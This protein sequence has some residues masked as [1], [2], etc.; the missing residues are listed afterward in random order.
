MQQAAATMQ[1]PALSRTDRRLIFV[2]MQQQLSHRRC[3]TAMK[4]NSIKKCADLVISLVLGCTKQHKRVPMETIHSLE[5]APV[6][7][8]LMELHGA[9][10][11]VEFAL[12]GLVS[13]FQTPLPAYF[14]SMYVRI[15]NEDIESAV[16]LSVSAE[17]EG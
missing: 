4:A 13:V 5:S 15:Y 7:T 14:R 3:L 8:W 2:L 10:L 17:S 1:H 12:S 11:H 16:A 9:R 6:D